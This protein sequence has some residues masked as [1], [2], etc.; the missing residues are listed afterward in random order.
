MSMRTST[1]GKA[2]PKPWA[3]DTFPAWVLYCA[4]ALI[5]FSLI[6]VGLI[7]IT[8]NGPDQRAAAA[9]AERTLRFEDRSDGGVAVLDGQS[10]Q[11][12]TV[13][14]GEQGFVRGTLRALARERHSRGIGN[15]PSFTL[16]AYV[17]QRLTLKDPATGARIDLESFGP[18]NMAE[19]ARFLPAKT[20]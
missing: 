4:G 11:L 6:S 7:R 5:A 8:G 3:P 2:S 10:G 13:L 16:T 1:I 20:P 15:G 17:D 18:T 14:R 19:F 9:V 12:L